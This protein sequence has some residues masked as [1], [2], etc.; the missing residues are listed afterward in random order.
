MPDQR[1]VVIAYDGSPAAREAVR[2]AGELFAGRAA[3]VVTVWSSVGAAS[4]GRAALPDEVVQVARERL[5]RSA[6]DDA[7]TVAD[8]GARLAS[9]CGLVA[10]AA[11]TAC[12]HSVWET[13][14]KVGEEEDAAVVVAGSQGRSAISAAL[15]G[16]AT[17]GLVRHAVRPVLIVPL[18]EAA[19][20]RPEG[21]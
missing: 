14:N 21:G 4:A 9:E 16:S 2:R 12:G 19:K 10:R 7:A 5:D 1:P 18:D 11:T 3:I 6:R 13:L 17:T 20:A 8:E 15:L